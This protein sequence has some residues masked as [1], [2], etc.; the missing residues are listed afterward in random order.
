MKET[1]I[2]VLLV[3]IVGTL[4]WGVEPLAHYVFYPKTDPADFA[5]NDL[6]KLPTTGDINNGKTLASTYCIAC[7]S[8]EKDGFSSAISKEDSISIYGVVPPDL[9]NIGAIYDDNFLANLIK[10]PVKTLQLTHK[11]NDTDKP[12][13]MT[14]TLVDDNE[15]G[16]IVAYFKSIG[17]KSLEI[18]VMESHEFISKS[19]SIENSS[20]LDKDKKEKLSLLKE[21]LTNKQVFISACTRCHSMKYDSINSITPTLDIENYLGAKAPDLSMMIRSRGEE[22]LSKFINNPQKML[23]NTS[24]PRVG[25][26]EDSQNRVIKYIENVGDSKKEE[27]KSV[28]IIVISFMIIMAIIAYLWKLKI[29]KEVH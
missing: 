2:L 7:H 8:I 27:R 26:T 25:L 9:S 6:E 4:Y 17:V 23:V 10:N 18:Q 11:F 24:M 14:P 12:F 22:Y 5:F 29:W 20:L 16:D 3:I 19:D 21:Y 28:G 13:P 15:L 1:K